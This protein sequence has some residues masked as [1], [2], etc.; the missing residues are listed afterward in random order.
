MMYSD[1][2][3]NIFAKSGS[4][5]AYCGYKQLTGDGEPENALPGVTKR[6]QKHTNEFI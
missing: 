5:D 3:W 1:M 4:V 2:F 6:E